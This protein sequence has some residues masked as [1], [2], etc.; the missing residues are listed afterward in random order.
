L[1]DAAMA[2]HYRTLTQVALG[3]RLVAVQ[4]KYLIRYISAVS[5]I[6][7]GAM[8][9]YGQVAGLGGDRIKLPDDLGTMYMTVD[10]SDNNQFREYYANATAAAAAIAGAPLPA[11]S[12][13]TGV[14]FKARLDA[15]GTPLKGPDQRFIKDELIGYI[16]MEKQA[17]W[18]AQIPSELRNGEWEYQLFTAAK[19]VNDK[20]NLKACYECHRDKVGAQKDFVFSLDRIAKK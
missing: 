11:G 18:G 6:S 14:L 9:A 2:L 1:A 5:L 8:A 16:V 20:A 19:I 17:G 7:A 3:A 12:M 13:L 4:N 10:R 15:Q